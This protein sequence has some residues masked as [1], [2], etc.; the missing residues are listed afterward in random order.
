M[1]LYH[2]SAEITSFSFILDVNSNF[3]SDFYYQNDSV[4]FRRKKFKIVSKC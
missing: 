1:E 4:L 3:N 2:A